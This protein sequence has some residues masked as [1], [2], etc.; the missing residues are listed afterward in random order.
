MSTIKE[1]FM[2]KD[3][4]LKMAIE[5]NEWLKSKLWV[6][7]SAGEEL[8]KVTNACKEAL[9]QPQPRLFLDLSNS[10]G[11]HPVNPPEQECK[12]CKSREVNFDMDEPE[13]PLCKICGKVLGS[14]KECAWT[15][16]PLNW[17]DEASEKR[18]DII[19]QNGN[20]GYGEE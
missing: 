6:D 1:N 14:T 12:W 18:Q 4:A 13:D 20:V 5:T 16:C 2:T 11:N 9:E 8:D 10:N 19:G 17:G 15:G 7:S 3:E